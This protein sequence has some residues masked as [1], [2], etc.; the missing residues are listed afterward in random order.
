[1]RSASVT[2]ELVGCR[3][4][5]LQSQSKLLLCSLSPQATR[6]RCPQATRSRCIAAIASASKPFSSNFRF[7]ASP[8]GMGGWS[9]P[10]MSGC[11]LG[12][13]IRTQSSTVMH[14]STG[15]W[16]DSSTVVDGIQIVSRARRGAREGL[17]GGSIM[18]AAVRKCLRNNGAGMQVPPSPRSTAA[19]AG[20]ASRPDNNANYNE[21]E[22]PRG[23]E[24]KH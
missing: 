2:T 13:R 11:P 7:F 18:S 24:L 4:I 23:E 5:V 10:Y 19:N 16:N 12:E 21:G 22:K 14:K 1:M 15:R 17:L 20:D 6:S 9:G 8:T 3:R